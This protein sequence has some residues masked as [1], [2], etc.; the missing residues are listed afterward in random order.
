[1]KKAFLFLKNKNFW[2]WLVITL[3]VA[4]LYVKGALIEKKAGVQ[5]NYYLAFAEILSVLFWG[6]AYKL[7]RRFISSKFSK[8]HGFLNKRPSIIYLVGFL[9]CIVVAAGLSFTKWSFFV[10]Q[11][12]NIAYFMLFW[13]VII[14]LI[15]LIKNKDQDSND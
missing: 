11:F 1:M 14:D 10:K 7:L 13:A 5:L 9:F 3:V 15:D 6:A 4:A 12:A 2:L 8:V